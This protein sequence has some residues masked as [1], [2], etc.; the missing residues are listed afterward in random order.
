MTPTVSHIP[1]SSFNCA[2]CDCG[3]CLSDA[4]KAIQE[5]DGVLHVRVDRTRTSLVVR[6]DE[7]LAD[8]RQFVDRI[9]AAKLDPV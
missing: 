9:R 5:V 2:G 3:S 6:Y 4:V 8:A 7:G 1:V